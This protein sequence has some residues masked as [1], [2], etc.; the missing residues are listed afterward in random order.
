M[1]SSGY[2]MFVQYI[3]CIHMGFLQVFQFQLTS[4]KYASKQS[5]HSK[6]SVGVMGFSLSN[7]IKARF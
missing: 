1:L 7:L 5:R 6:M 3:K 2:C 4:K